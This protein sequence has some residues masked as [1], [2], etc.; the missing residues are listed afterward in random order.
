LIDP[1]V[2]L[3]AFAIL[4]GGIALVIVFLIFLSERVFNTEADEYIVKLPSRILAMIVD[5]AIFSLVIELLL[6]ILIPGYVSLFLIPFIFPSVNPLVTLMA[7]F[8]FI[9]VSVS[10]FL[11]FYMTFIGGV[12][13]SLTSILVAITGFLYFFVFD[14]FLEGRTVGRR[15]LRLKTLHKSK[16]R[17]LSVGEAAV[18]AIG[19]TFLLL[20]LFLGTLVSM[21]ENRNNGLRQV[22]L[23]QKLAGVLIVKTSLSNLSNGSISLGFLQDDNDPG[24]LW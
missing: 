23:T 13:F 6:I 10:S 22:R 4:F 8:V 19:K 14:A 24:A 9:G 17:T 3:L 5:I 15:V 2:F 12:G 20:D 18:N 11:V 21:Y 1:N 7:V 16:N